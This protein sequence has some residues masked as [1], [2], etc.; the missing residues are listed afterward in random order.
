MY[1]CIYI[2][3]YLYVY[4]LLFAWRSILRAAA[5]ESLQRSLVSFRFFPGHHDGLGNLDRSH[6]CPHHGQ[7]L[8]EYTATFEAMVFMDAMVKMSVPDVIKD[9]LDISELNGHL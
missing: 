6:F 9:G 4:I 7:H 2:C 5:K 1:V 8:D 3:I